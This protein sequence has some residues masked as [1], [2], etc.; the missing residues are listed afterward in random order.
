MVE[1]RTLVP[2]AGGSIPPAPAIKRHE[3]ESILEEEASWVCRTCPT[4]LGDADQQYCR[5]CAA[6]WQDVQNGLF[7]D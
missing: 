1:H 2:K 6:Y 4:M 7:G 5:H 3:A